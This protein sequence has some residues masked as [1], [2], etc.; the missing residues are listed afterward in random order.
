MYFVAFEQ[1]I[2]LCL[3]SKYHVYKKYNS[4]KKAQED[5]IR[6][7]KITPV[8]IFTY[9]I[10]VCS[11]FTDVRQC[12]SCITYLFRAF[13]ISLCH[14]FLGY[15]F[16]NFCFGFLWNFLEM[17][18]IPIKQHSCWWILSFLHFFNYRTIVCYK[19]FLGI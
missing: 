5:D 4:R 9:L 16:V 15:F 17:C 1:A 7:S 6:T 14:I 8:N 2:C 18:F 12:V 19:K 13:F 10:T 3:K 11:I